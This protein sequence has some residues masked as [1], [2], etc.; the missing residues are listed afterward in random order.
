MAEGDTIHR[1]AGRIDAAFGGTAPDGVRTPGPRRPQGDPSRVVGRELQAARAR[2]KHLLLDFE[3]GV[4]LHSHLGMNGGW[5]IYR[6]GAR[7]R[8]SPRSAWLVLD[9]SGQELV[10]FRGS[11]IRIGRTAELERRPPLATLGP[12]ILDPGFDAEAVAPRLAASDPSRPLA[13]ALL[14]QVSVAGIGNIFKNEA[15]H[16]AGL[17]PV[18]PVGGYGRESL[19]RVLVAARDQMRAAVDGA[20]RP[21]EVYKR[22]GEPCRR[23]GGRVRSGLVGDDARTTFWC[24]RC[25]TADRVHSGR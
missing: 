7:W 4:T 22:A 23:C 9:W 19:E 17:D 10:N 3:G 6:R 13:E 11:T 14:D 20:G 2:G 1:L 24:P 5:H 18:A 21:R 25:Q 12:D 16:A 15:C 8:Y